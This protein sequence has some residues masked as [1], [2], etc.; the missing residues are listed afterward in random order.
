MQLLFGR[1]I[2]RVQEN[3]FTRTEKLA[4]KGIQWK[5][6]K[7]CQDATKNVKNMTEYLVHYNSQFLIYL[8]Y[9]CSVAGL[10]IVFSHRL[11]RKHSS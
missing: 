2:L 10:G 4:K 5:C 7:I 11:K 3:I 6:D 8:I 1:S 9:K